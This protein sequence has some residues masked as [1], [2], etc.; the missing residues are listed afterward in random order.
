MTKKCASDLKPC[1]CAP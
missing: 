1:P